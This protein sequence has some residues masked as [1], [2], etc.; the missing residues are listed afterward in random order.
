MSLT[1]VKGHSH[2]AEEMP[3]ISWHSGGFTSLYFG[4]VTTVGLFFPSSF[5]WYSQHRLLT[6]A[7]KDSGEAE[8]YASPRVPWQGLEWLVVSEGAR[9]R[10]RTNRIPHKCK[11]CIKI[12]YLLRTY[13]EQSVAYVFFELL[14]VIAVVQGISLP[15]SSGLRIFICI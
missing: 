5:S 13:F 1:P 15:V 8:G 14:G 12:R 9:T 11:F 4:T 6:Q 3:Q 10:K 2:I 7:A